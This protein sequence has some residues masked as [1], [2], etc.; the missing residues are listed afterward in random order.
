MSMHKTLTMNMCEYI[1][2]IMFPLKYVFGSKY[3]ATCTASQTGIALSTTQM[4]GVRIPRPTTCR[5]IL[6]VSNYKVREGCESVAIV[7][8][9]LHSSK[10]IEAECSRHPGGAQEILRRA[11]GNQSRSRLGPANMPSSMPATLD[12]FYFVLCTSSPH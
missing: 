1:I 9:Q 11:V 8:V 5:F 10:I 7:H 2:S 3:I 6:F 12:C 4:A